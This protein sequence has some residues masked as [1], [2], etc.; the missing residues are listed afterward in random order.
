MILNDIVHKIRT[1]QRFLV[2]SHE[3]PDGDAVGSTLALTLALKKM[4]K[5]VVAFN[6]DGVPG[7]LAFL[8][9]TQSVR[10]SLADNETFD[11]GFL[12]D[13]G[14]LKRAGIPMQ[15]H[16]NLLINIDHHP[17]S[18]F[19]DI[20]YLDTTASA[21]AVL[22][23]RLLVACDFTLDIEVAKALYVGVLDDTGS[24]RYSSA[25]REA[26]ELAGVLV[27]C[28]V[29]PWQIASSLY[30]SFT[31]TRMRLLG[32]VLSTLDISP[33]GRYASVSLIQEFLAQSGAT[34]EESDGFVNYARAVKGVEIAL[35][36]KEQ[37]DGNYQISFRSRGNI[38]VGT[39]ARQLGGGGHHN[40]AGARIPAESLDAVRTELYRHLDLL[41]N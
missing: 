6:V 8:P 39:L 2:V 5:D 3:S 26:F 27:E 24:F 36:I 28:G 1:S 20:C 16:C 30:E 19:G 7:N 4:G 11:V 40:A 15:Q 35:F 18:D 25:N 41:L 34:S 12:I 22:I 13:A 31:I 14:E 23:Y 33:C 21:T 32:L 17:H 38:D 10:T 29:D 9:G 37:A